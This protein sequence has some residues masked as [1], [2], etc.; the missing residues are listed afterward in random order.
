MSNFTNLNTL[1]HIKR[2]SENTIT[3]YI[4]LLKSFDAY[5][6]DSLAIHR[7]DTK[8][9]FQKLREFIIDKKYAYTTQKQLLS[10]LKLYMK[11]MYNIPLDLQT[12]TPRKPQRVLPDILSK[13]E[14]TAMLNRTANLKHK[15]ILATIYSLGLRTGE[16]QHLKLSH[17]DGKRNII[18]IKQAKGRKDRILPFPES[19]KLLLRDYYKEYR[20]NWYLFEG[21][22]GKQYSAAS[23]RAVFNA[24]CKRAAIVKHVTPH[25]LRHAYATHVLESGTSLKAIQQLLGHTNIKTTMLYT[26][27][28]NRSVLGVKSPLDDLKLDTT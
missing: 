13:E 23:V 28:S 25:S 16:L 24:A 9:L 15:S 17:L 21:Q 5:L 6:G 26:Q 10:A 11:E 2:Y 14:V 27:V 20:P 1:M 18:S 3:A 8:H 12:L 4:G 7:L 22:S 19:L